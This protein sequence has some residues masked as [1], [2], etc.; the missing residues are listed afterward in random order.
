MKNPKSFN[1]KTDNNCIKLRNFFDSLVF[2]DFM[3]DGVPL[4]V[5]RT[6]AMEQN[7]AYGFLINWLTMLP[8][9]NE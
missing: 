1:M 3:R 2:H 5:I 4:E 6:E 8:I 9:S 7:Y